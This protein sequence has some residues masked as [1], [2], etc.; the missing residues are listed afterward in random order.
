MRHFALMTVPLPFRHGPCRTVALALA[1][2]LFLTSCGNV[3][4]AVVITDVPPASRGGPDRMAQI[5]GRVNGARP[6]DAV[7]LFA[8][9]ALW[10][11]QPFQLT[12]F[13]TIRDDGTW[14]ASTH[15][16]TEYAAMLVRAGYQP[17][18]TIETLP[19]VGELVIA[20]AR[21]SGSADV[22]RPIERTVSFSGYRWAVRQTSS[23]RGGFNQYSADNV[24]VADDGALHMSI[25]ERDRIWT[26]SEIVLTR[27][28]GY[29]TYTFSVRD[30]G[31][32]DPAAL[33]SFYTYDDEGPAENFRE[34]AI[35]LR[36]PDE[37]ARLGGQYVLQPNYVAANVS[38]FVV[39]PGIVTHSLRWEPGRAVFAT[40]RGRRP[41]PA[42]PNGVQ[43]EFTVGV[44][45][46]GKERIRI[47]LYYF[48]NAPLPPQHQ[49]EVVIDQFQHFP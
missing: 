23:D 29:G 30:A 8:K 39:P 3:P 36:R 34:M 24:R 17:P 16:G 5:S 12:P 15:L 38:R 9:S 41:P 32:L 27:S 20:V 7:V 21:V 46:A 19:P 45:S 44:P 11:V 10:Y 47:A 13:T 6:G 43:H 42:R 35:S 25:T 33:L 22:L 26:S 18:P 40:N 14:T 49:V 1:A 2:A 31:A 4:P 37:R 48:R 28:L